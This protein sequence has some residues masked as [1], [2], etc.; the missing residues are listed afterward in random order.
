MAQGKN[1]KLGKKGKQK[2]AIEPFL[3]K[4]W[5]DVKAP[6]MFPITDLGKTPVQRSAGTHNCVDSLRGRVFEVSLGDLKP[7]SEEDAYRKFK[8][9]VEDVHGRNCLT[10]FHGMSITTDK[11]RS[12]VRKWQ[13][14]IEAHVDV[15]T[16]DGYGLRIFVIGFTKRQKEQQRKTTYA[17]SSQIHAI[18]KKMTQI[19]TRE[20]SSVD[21]KELVSKLVAEIIGKEI[22]KTCQGIFPMQDVLIRKVK[23]LHTP[24]ADAARLLELHKGV[25]EADVGKAVER[26][27][28]MPAAAPAPAA[29][30]KKEHK[31][32]A[33]KKA[34]AAPA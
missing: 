27:D 24:K 15:K 3:K 14:T 20:C 33:E 32:P 30:D 28:E 13:T 10:N 11:L 26:E 31:A 9:R 19:I 6:G 21:L 7:N 16:T 29:A 4:E 1:K 12:L 34:A 18:R 25:A 17:M 22:E 8:F 5:Y 23:M 2:R